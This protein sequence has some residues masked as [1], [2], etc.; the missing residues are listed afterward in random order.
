M[1]RP[2]NLD[3]LSVNDNELGEF[4]RYAKKLERR[5]EKALFD[6]PPPLVPT[7]LNQME[8]DLGW[9]AHAGMIGLILAEEVK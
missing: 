5:I 3:A 8:F 2:K 4:A 1:R 7:G 6:T 9:E